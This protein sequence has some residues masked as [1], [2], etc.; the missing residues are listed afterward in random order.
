ML[1]SPSPRGGA[2]S[3]HLLAPH[4]HPRLKPQPGAHACHRPAWCLS[5]SLRE[6]ALEGWVSMKSLHRWRQNSCPADSLLGRSGRGRMGRQPMRKEGLS[7]FFSSSYLFSFRLQP[8]QHL[9]DRNLLTKRVPKRFTKE[10]FIR[11]DPQS[12]A[13]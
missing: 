4:L 11:L 7:S 10:Q 12:C 9:P 2:E 13:F 8:P 6:E 3:H 1:V 5:L